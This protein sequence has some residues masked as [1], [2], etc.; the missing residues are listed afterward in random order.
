MP[1][2]CVFDGKPCDEVK[3]NIGWEGNE[4]PTRTCRFKNPY[5]DDDD[6]PCVVKA[7][8]S[9]VTLYHDVASVNPNLV[10]TPQE[11]IKDYHKKMTKLQKKIPSRMMESTD[12]KKK[13]TPKRKVC[14]CK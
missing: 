12:R 8:H 7:Y 13:T 1:R 2:N 10:K 5:Y 4:G 14:R 9:G 3:Y 6:S 11:A